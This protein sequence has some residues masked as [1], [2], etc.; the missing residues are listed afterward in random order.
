[1]HFCK[2]VIREYVTDVLGSTTTY[3]RAVDIDA[4]TS[5]V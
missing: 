5:R 1:M 2:E 4:A 3:G